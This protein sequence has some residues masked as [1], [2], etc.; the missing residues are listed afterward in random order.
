ML[1]VGGAIVK[2]P[3]EML[4]ETEERGRSRPNSFVEN[5]D[6]SRSNHQRG[7]LNPDATSEQI[8]IRKHDRAENRSRG[9]EMIG[10]VRK[11]RSFSSPTPSPRIS[12]FER[13][14]TNQQQLSRDPGP[15]IITS[16]C[17]DQTTKEDFNSS[18]DDTLKPTRSGRKGLA[19]I[20]Q[21]PSDDDPGLGY[22]IASVAVS[23]GRVENDYECEMNYPSDHG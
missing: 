15:D 16:T 8:G 13:G 2:G 7:E 12:H 18:A 4:R 23:S 20:F 21:P 1:A 3:A 10:T 19:S 22:D 14:P 6:A 17:H 11:V 5:H 9:A